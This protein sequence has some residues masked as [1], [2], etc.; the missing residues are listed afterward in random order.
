MSEPILIIIGNPGEATSKYVG[1][2][3]PGSIVVDD[4]GV[5]VVPNDLHFIDRSGSMERD[6]VIKLADEVDRLRDIAVKAP[7][8]IED[9]RVPLG[10]SPDQIRRRKKDWEVSTGKGWRR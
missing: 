1:E 6:M 10:K 3:P 2:L 7:L 9:L 8:D 5:M 4:L